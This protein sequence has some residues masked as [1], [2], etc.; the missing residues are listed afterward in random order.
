VS[1]MFDNR[2]AAVGGN[3]SSGLCTPQIRS[4]FM[5]SGADGGSHFDSVGC[6]VRR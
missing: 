3:L 6:S 2:G 5:L 1:D 4:A